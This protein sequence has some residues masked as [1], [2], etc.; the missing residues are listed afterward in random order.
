MNLFFV[1]RTDECNAKIFDKL[2][3][4]KGI[5]YRKKKTNKQYMYVVSTKYKR[6]YDYRAGAYMLNGYTLTSLTKGWL[7]SYNALFPESVW[8]SL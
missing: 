7:Q 4:S 1:P 5:K 3:K 8:E 2:F 6:H